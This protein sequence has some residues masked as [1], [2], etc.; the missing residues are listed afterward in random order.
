MK[1]S[2][3]ILIL[4]TF[5]KEEMKL[6][7]EFLHS[8]FHNKNK[9]VIKLYS[10]LKRH[11]P[12]NEPK[13]I[14]KP[15]LFREMFKDKNYSESYIRNLLSD[16]N[17]LA[18]IFLK[19]IHFDKDFESEKK[20]I[21]EFSRRN[22]NKL[23]IKKLNDFENSVNIEP[24]KDHDYFMHKIFIYDMK[25][26]FVSDKSLTNRYMPDAISAK[27]KLS[28]IMI[29]ES[30]FQYLVEEQRIKVKH[31]FDYLL[32][33]LEYLKNHVN[34]F[35]DSPLLQVYYHLWMSFLESDGEKSFS[36]AGK[37]FRTSFRAFTIT[38]KKNI[39][40]VMKTFCLK[41]IEEGFDSYERVLLNIMLEMLRKNVTSHKED[42]IN[43][44]LYRNVLLTCFKLNDLKML[45]KFISDYFKNTDPECRDS[46]LT[47]SDAHREFLK[48][49]YAGSLQLASKM[50]FRNLFISSGESFYFKND[51]KSLILKCLYELNYNENAFN[52]IDSYK[53]FL[54]N[55]LLIKESLKKKYM[56]FINATAAMIKLKSEYD[57][58]KYHKIKK[59]VSE[60]NDIVSKP[61]LLKKLNEFEIHN[62]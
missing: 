38:D 18:E 50:N 2:S 48:G 40:A 24:A 17:I 8:P 30:Y 56:T 53:H 14:S 4:E 41:R 34:E 31:N 47:F 42:Y 29:M 54:N 36:K 21:G 25:G 19:V 33:T 44:N 62:N 57:E 45:N 26:L 7:G 9:K 23:L 10:V 16:L 5:S 37:I 61:W 13:K 12:F 51:I 20:L 46:I 43:L 55:S 11:Y 39:Y 59:S 32:H 58:Y 22:I 49:N 3:A 35:S 27:I 52:H 28:L 15:E 60:R 6:F 1:K